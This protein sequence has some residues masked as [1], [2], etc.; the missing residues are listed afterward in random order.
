M[1]AQWRPE[2]ETCRLR[3]AVVAS[4]GSGVVSLTLDGQTSTGVPVYGPMPAAGAGVL[5][6]EQGASLLVLGNAVSL[7][8]RLELMEGRL[9]ALEAGG[10]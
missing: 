6:L 5:V 2:R 4:V 9:A 1:S 10:A 3:N 7:A 8:D